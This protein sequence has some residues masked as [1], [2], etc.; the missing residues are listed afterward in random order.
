MTAATRKLTVLEAEPLDRDDVY[1]DRES[2]L[3]VAK[4]RK[5]LSQAKR[6]HV[7]T[8]NVNVDVDE[9]GLPIMIEVIQPREYWARRKAFVSE[10][11]IR[12]G[13]VAF[14]GP[15]DYRNWYEGSAV[16]VGYESEPSALVELSD[17]SPVTG[18]R[19]SPRVTVFV[20]AQELPVL[21]LFRDIVDR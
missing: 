15:S 5:P 11:P 12:P 4:M 16:V 7:L 9:I 14:E 3:L 13:G 6:L 10:V 8:E 1:Y 17:E 18:V 2:G 21:I 20:S 19:I